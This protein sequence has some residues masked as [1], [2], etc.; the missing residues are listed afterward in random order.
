MSKI[1]LPALVAQLAQDGLDVAR[2]EVRLVKARLSIRLSEAKTGLIFLAAAALLALLGLIGLV[3][4]LVGALATLVGPGLAGLI[5]MLAFLA[6][7]GLLG[8]LG[9]R[10]LSAK[11]EPITAPTAL[12]A[13]EHHG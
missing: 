13:L 9:A 4:G 11:P 8:W 10:R 1:T 2:A 12:P 7:A 5:V 6:V 3:V